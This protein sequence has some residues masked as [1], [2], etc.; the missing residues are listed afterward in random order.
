MKKATGKKKRAA[1]NGLR[2]EYDLKKLGVGVRGKYHQRYAEGACLVPLDPDV[3]AAF[4]SAK[5]V[6]EA[7]RALVTVA[8]QSVR[9]GRRSKR[10]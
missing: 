10:S 7:L 8:S 6:N 5:D 2:K 9:P 3:A 4:P 1:A